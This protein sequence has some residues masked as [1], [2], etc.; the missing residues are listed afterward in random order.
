MPD[1]DH[2]GVVLAGLERRDEQDV[3][4]AHGQAGRPLRTRRERAGPGRQ[5]VLGR[6]GEAAPCSVVGDVGGGEMRDRQ[7]MVGVRQAAFEPGAEACDAGGREPFR[8]ADG[9]QVVQQQGGADASR[10]QR[11]QQA[12]AAADGPGRAERD[13]QVA[14]GGP[15]GAGGPPRLGRRHRAERA[16]WRRAHEMQQRAGV[17]Q[18]LALQHG[19][20]EQRVTQLGREAQDRALHARAA[21]LVVLRLRRRLRQRRGG[22]HRLERGP[23]DRGQP[24][25][26]RAAA[27]EPDA[28]GRRI[29]Q[30]ADDVERHALDAARVRIEAEIVEQV[31]H[32]DPNSLCRWHDP[33]FCRPRLFPGSGPQRQEGGVEAADGR[34]GS[35]AVRM[36][37]AKAEWGERV[38]DAKRTRGLFP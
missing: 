12:G 31:L 28:L 37:Q 11:F 34:C 20:A 9:D 33:Q 30:R 25:A 18:H 36:A 5:D 26:G 23:L 19:G 10:P 16:R 24:A 21:D 17:A 22:H 4:P 8:A 13:E 27:G 2:Q 14:A 3:A 6:Q 32:I 38:R 7:Q 35:Q 15:E 1:L 29:E